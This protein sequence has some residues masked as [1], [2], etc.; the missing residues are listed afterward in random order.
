MASFP[1]PTGRRRTSLAMVMAGALVVSVAGIA[2]ATTPA[3]T[4]IY[5]CVNIKTEVVV[6]PKHR[7]SVAHMCSMNEREIS[8]D[9]QGR[10]VRPGRQG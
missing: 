7:F 10:R 6:I 8:W 5:A 9:I 2:G 1:I 4:K 3:P